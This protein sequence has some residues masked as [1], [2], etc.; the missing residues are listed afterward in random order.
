MQRKKFWGI[1]ISAVVLAGFLATLGLAAYSSHQN[2][3]D[4]QAFL[5]VYPFAKGTKLD[6]CSLCHPGGSITQGTKTTYYGSCDYCHITYGLTPPHGQVPL[7]SYGQA[8]EDAGRN[9]D[10]IRAIEG[11]NSDGDGY[12]NL[13]EIRGLF[14]PGDANDYPGLKPAP[15]VVMNLERILELP[16]H[17]QFML[18]NATKQ[19]KDDYARYDGVKIKDLLQSL[20]MSRKATQITVYAPDG[21]SKAFPIDAPDPQTA[22][23]FQYDVMGPY[24]KGYYYGGLDFV[25][26]AFDPGYP[27]EDGYPIPDKL[28][29]LFG[30]LREGDPLDKGRLVPD[31]GNPGRLVLEGEGPYRL[32][33]P[34]KVAGGPDRSSTNDPT[35][36][37]W[38]YN[39]N[40]DHNAGASV[41]SIAAIKVDPLPSGTTD[42]RWNEGGWNLVD[43]GRVVIYGA[44]DPCD[45]PVIGKIKD[46]NGKAIQEVNVSVGLLSLGQIQQA[47]SDKYGRFHV[48]LPA[49]EYILIPSKEGY[50]FDP[51]SISIQISGKGGRFIH[52]TGAPNP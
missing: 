33:V 17:S 28:Y 6:D 20:R 23:N 12:D 2:D 40:N 8:Y 50:T 10:A 49:G 9:E 44:I 35:N 7:N 26:Y 5:A 39:S 41:R 14:Y 13:A 47:I 29:M 1:F 19:L 42:F 32:I 16:S 11:F 48:D 36:D 37:K 25:N 31:P 52:F 18:N 45:F 43:K 21:F 22:P 3:K 4:V 46:N 24:P 30:Y 38:K 51:G 27:H 15:T 34:Q